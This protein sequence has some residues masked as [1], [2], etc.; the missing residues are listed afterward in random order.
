MVGNTDGSHCHGY[1]LLG[2]A[3]H[4]DASPLRPN[5]CKWYHLMLSYSSSS[6]LLFEI[7]ALC[8]SGG[9]IVYMQSRLLL[10]DI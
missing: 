10:S 1:K 9:G 4:S 3:H 2:S 6:S 5:W 7:C 8:G